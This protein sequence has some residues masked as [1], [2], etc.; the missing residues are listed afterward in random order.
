MTSAPPRTIT[1]SAPTITDA[2]QYQIARYRAKNRWTSIATNTP[3]M[4]MPTTGALAATR[5]VRGARTPH[6]RCSARLLLA[7]CRGDD[8]L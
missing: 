8:R 3:S 2:S 5:P 7:Q 4:T 1:A 6:P